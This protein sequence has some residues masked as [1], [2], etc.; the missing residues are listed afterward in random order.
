MALQA[1]SFLTLSAF[2]TSSALATLLSHISRV[3][4]IP[5]LQPEEVLCCELDQLHVAAVLPAGA[6]QRAP[7]HGVLLAIQQFLHEVVAIP[8]PLYPGEHVDHRPVVQCLNPSSTSPPCAHG[9][10]RHVVGPEPVFRHS[11]KER[12]RLDAPVLSV[13]GDDR[14]PHGDVPLWPRRE[15]PVRV[16]EAPATEVHVHERAVG[17][18]V[19]THVRLDHL[20]A[21]PCTRSRAAILAHAHSTDANVYW[22]GRRPSGTHRVEQRHR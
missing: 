22:S 16:L 9:E 6:Q 18:D 2:I 15:R 21:T 17:E 5:R 4:D 12:E 11:V 20:T 1:G 13:F 14:R 19:S 10:E 7:D 3:A 8:E